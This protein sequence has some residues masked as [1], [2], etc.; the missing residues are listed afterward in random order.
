MSQRIFVF[1]TARCFGC[2]GC[3]AACA[4]I[5]QTPADVLWRTVHK[6]PPWD[7][8]HGTVYLS[9]S[10]NHCQEPPCVKSCP[11]NALEKRKSD[12]IVIH[13]QEKCLGCRYCQMACPY[14]AIKWDEQA[15]VVS[16]CHFCYERVDKGE[17]PA[18]VETCFGGALTMELLADNDI[19]GQYGKESPGLKYFETIGPGMRIIDS[20]SK[21]K[22]EKKGDKEDKAGGSF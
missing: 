22:M 2:H 6:L 7:G 9:V 15:G 1:D 3:V 11:A 10:C 18:C 4:N 8:E 16:K 20:F 12:G 17:K 21:S 5:N 14:D 13:D 19:S